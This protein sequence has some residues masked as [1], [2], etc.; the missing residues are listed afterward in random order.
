MTKIFPLVLLME[1]NNIVETVEDRIQNAILTAIHNI[2]A[3]KIELAI[4][5]KNASSGRHVT[6]VSAN[7]ERR[8]HTGINASF[9]NA[10]ENN[11][12]LGVTSINDETRR[13]FQDEV[14][15]SSV[16]GTQFGRRSHTHHTTSGGSTETHH[17]V[18]GVINPSHHMVKGVSNPTHHKNSNE[19]FK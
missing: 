6:S 8:E 10:S 9:E 7:S 3:P 4:R 13:N 2:V 19:T 18:K 17:M 12:T 5:S 14:S 1:M 16:Q 11:N 15:E